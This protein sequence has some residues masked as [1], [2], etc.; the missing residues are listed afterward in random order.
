MEVD[1][2]S[3]L[4]EI[5]ILIVEDNPEERRL[6]AAILEREGY[7][8]DAAGSLK[9]ARQIMSQRCYGVLLVDL[10]LGDGDGTELLA[11]PM[12]KPRPVVILITAYASLRSALGALRRGAYDYLTKPYDS[13]VLVTTVHR[14]AEKF[15]L[16]CALAARTLQLESANRQMRERVEEATREISRLNRRLKQHVIRLAQS[17]QVQNQVVFDV[18]HELRN[19]LMVIK[20]FSDCLLRRETVGPAARSGEM[21]AAIRCGV[22][23]LLNLISDLA[24]SCRLANG[25][26]SLQPEEFATGALI[27]DAVDGYRLQAGKRGLFIECLLPDGP[28]PTVYAD[29]NRLR[30][31]LG[32][33]IFNAMKFTRPGGR[34]TVSAREAGGWT[35]FDVED[36]GIGMTPEDSARVFERFYQAAQPRGQAPGF[37][38]GLSIVKALVEAQGGRIGVVTRRN[39]GSRFFF[40]LPAHRPAQQL[41]AADGE[42]TKASPQGKAPEKSSIFGRIQS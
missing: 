2:D 22:Y 9:E 33:L 5:P 7:R 23:T 15:D 36:T 38:L 14:A 6:M 12:A 27:R 17:R 10:R 21:L 16:E 31:I 1:M 40:T 39:V 29:P 32:N 20:G 8:L 11:L 18:I 19:P 35:L 42:P 34:V 41:V 25:K 13:D 28:G 24:D 4:T 30:Q 26:L 3:A 37:G